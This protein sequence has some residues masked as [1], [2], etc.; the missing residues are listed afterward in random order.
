VRANKAELG[1]LRGETEKALAILDFQNTPQNG[2]PLVQTRPRTDD[3]KG[4][5]ANEAGHILARLGRWEEAV[6]AYAQALKAVPDDP[7]YLRNKASC[8]IEL[9]LYGEADEALAR[10][11][12]LYPG[13]R[14]LD[15]I[16]YVAIKKGEYPRAEA[17]YRI[18]LERKPA[19]PA[20]LAGLAWTLL[21]MGRW[22]AAEEIILRLERSSQP[23]SNAATKAAELRVQYSEA[24]TRIVSCAACALTW[25][26]DKFASTTPG[27]RLVAEPPDDMPAGSCTSCGK[28]L[29]IGCA[30]KNM[31]DGRFICP[32]C[33]E[34]LKLL[35]EGLKKILSDWASMNTNGQSQQKI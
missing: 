16:A 23:G 4:E 1:F 27:I 29:C 31:A 32:D 15:L 9:G 18:G 24:T 20:L 25:K 26:V 28:T 35:D 22:K 2:Q 12:E 6:G 13:T 34:R 5:L 21:S 33:G 11:Y 14:T 3:P 10:S 8:L 17:C 30:K 19:D 7:D